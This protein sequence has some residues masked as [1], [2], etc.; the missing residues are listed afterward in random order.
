M[1]FVYKL[2]LALF[3]TANVAL[4]RIILEQVKLF[5]FLGSL[6]TW[7]SHKVR[8]ISLREALEKIAD[9]QKHLNWTK[10]EFAKCFV[11]SVVIMIPKCGQ[12]ESI[13]VV[14]EMK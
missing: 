3:S 8:G 11:W 6:V 7:K 9:G 10:E 2:C 5:P 4:E 1:H 12:L 14:M 13:D